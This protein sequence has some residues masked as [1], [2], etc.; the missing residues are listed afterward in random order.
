MVG[1]N[2]YLLNVLQRVYGMAQL[3][4][5]LLIGSDSRNQHVSNPNGLMDVGE[6]AGTI[7]YVLVAVTCKPT[8][9]LAI[10]VLDVEQYQ[11]GSLH[12][13]LELIK[14]WLLASKR[15]SSCVE[16]GVDAATMGLLEQVD[17]KINLQQ[18]LASANGDAAIGAPVAAVALGLVEQFTD[19]CRCATG[20]GT[21]AP[22]VGV[23]AVAA[24]HLTTL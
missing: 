13:A 11:V 2:F 3:D 15:L 10:D 22:G 9:L 4:E 7:Q 16:T 6:I 17:Q 5:L 19:R 18:S 24:A 14:E 12:Q 23:V 21:S 20:V 8:M 1:Q